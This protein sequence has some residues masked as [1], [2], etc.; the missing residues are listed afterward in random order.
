MVAIAII[1]KCN[2][3]SDDENE[4]SFSSNNLQLFCAGLQGASGKYK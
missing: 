4:I 3:F 1:C 2:V